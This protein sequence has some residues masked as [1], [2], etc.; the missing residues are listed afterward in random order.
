MRLFGVLLVRT[1]EGDV[2]AAD[3]E[4]R[5]L[6]FLPRGAKGIGHGLEIIAVGQVLD[7]PAVGLEALAYVFLTESEIGG[8]LDGDVV[9]VVKKDQVV[10]PQEA[11]DGRRFRRDTLHQ[12]AVA[13]DAIDLVVQNLMSGPVEECAQVFAGDRHAH[14]VAETLTQRTGG[15]FNARSQ[16]VLR[17]AGRFASPL[18]ELLDLVQRKV[19][20]GQVEQAV[21]KHA[22]VARRE[23][24]A[25]AIW[26]ARLEGIVSEKA[27][28]QHIRHGRSTHRQSRVPRIRLLDRIHGEAADGVNTKLVEL[29]LIES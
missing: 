25:I 4:R 22:A 20:A 26:P 5:P 6:P 11:G 2:G 16:Q 17:M 27:C 21:K 3:D 13:A 29:G 10:E 14:R 15:G 12:V 19:I 7:K 24:E 18:A 23:H 9:V 1:A 28:P 8:T